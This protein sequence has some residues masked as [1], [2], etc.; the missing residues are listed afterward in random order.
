[1]SLQEQIVR[2]R[3]FSAGEINPDAIRRDDVDALK[4]GLRYARNV[5]SS[6]TGGLQ[7]RPGR[8]L[9]FQDDG[10]IGEFKPFDDISYT[11][12][13]IAGGVKIR[14]QDAALVAFLPGPWGEADLDTLVWETMDNEAIVAWGGL[15]QVITIAENTQAWSIAPFSFGTGVDGAFRMPFYRFEATANVTMRPDGL[16]GAINVYFSAP[17]LSPLHAGTVFRYGGRQLRLVT[18]VT[19]FSATADVIEHLPPTYQIGLNSS[20]GFSVGQIVATDTTNAKGEVVAV[21]PGAVG[22]VLIDNLTVPQSGENLVG[23]TASSKIIAITSAAA[24]AAVSWDEQFISSFRGYPR[25]VAKDRQ[26]LIFSNFKQKKNAIAWSAV[27]DNRDFSIGAEADDAMLE[28]IS[29]ECQIY[30]V[31]GGYDEFAITDKGVFYIP[32]SD[33]TPLKPGSVEFLP[34][35]SSEL[36]NIRPVQ[37]TEGLIFVDKTLTGIYAITATGQ[38][39]RPYSANEVNMLHRH[40][41][42]GVKSIAVSSGSNIFPSRQIYAVNQDGTV[43]VGQFNP[44]TSYIGWLKWDGDGAVRSVTGTYGRVVCI[45]KYPFDGDGFSVAEELDY[46]LFCDCSVTFDG[47]SSAD[48]VELVDG[49]PLRLKDGSNLSLNGVVTEVFAG[50]EVAVFGDGFYLGE[51]MVGDDG[52]LSEISGYA[53]LTVGVRFDWAFEPL[54]PHFEGGQPVGQAEQRRK[55][56]KMLITTRD[57]QEFQVGQRI[58]G[59]H[60]GGEDTSLPIPARDDTYRYREIGRSYDPV[61]RFSSTF[62]CKFKLIELTTRIT[63]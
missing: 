50:K 25:S 31:V 32:I 14:T 26:R 4:S 56:A 22:V 61:V 53:Q 38:V 44:D 58:F 34:I 42:D 30:H 1:M 52:L 17:I 8:K 37:V 18:I 7:I 28:F 10:V 9:L 57:T 40:L 46:S 3:D 60:R 35:F 11:L 19:P 23:P 39:A 59:S 24:G 16:T 15:M 51:H 47:E 21:A 27:G 45:T 33:G 29:A 55:I 2:Q 13:F 5:V 43:V 49:S 6:H 62:P 20:D 36:A 12:V 54:F 63:V 41:F 48:F